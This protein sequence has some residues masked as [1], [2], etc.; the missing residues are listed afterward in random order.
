MSRLISDLDERFQP[1]VIKFT[2]ILRY[3]GV[4][5]SILETRRSHAVQIAY[6]SQ[7]RD[8]FEVVNAK[9]ADAGLPLIGR[10]EAKR[11]ITRTLLSKHIEGLAVDIVPLTSSGSIPWNLKSKSIADMWRNIGNIGTSCGLEWGG[12]WE[13]LNE[14]GLGWDL[15]HYEM[16]EEI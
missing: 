11:K 5:F 2:E 3:K 15:P 1:F 4:L 13:P 14:Y 8:V 16:K 9:R 10:E 12:K 6:Y 7:G